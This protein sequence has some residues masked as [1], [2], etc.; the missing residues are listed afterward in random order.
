[1]DIIGR[2]CKENDFPFINGLV[3]EKGSYK[4]NSGFWQSSWKGSLPIELKSYDKQT[5]ENVKKFQQQICQDTKN[6]GYK[7][8]K[9]F[10]E[11]L[12]KFEQTKLKNK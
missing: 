1:M 11:K 2:C 8:R 12:E 9:E 6:K 3:I 7:G 10:L 4:I 5:E